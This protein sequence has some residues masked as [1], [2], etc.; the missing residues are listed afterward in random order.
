MQWSFVSVKFICNSWNLGSVRDHPYPFLPCGP[1]AEGVL[2]PASVRPSVHMTKLVHAIT[3]RNI[4]QIFLKLGL[5]IFLV[6]ISDKIKDGYRSSLSHP[7]IPG[8]TLCFCTGSYAGAGTAGRR[9]LYKRY[10]LNNFLY[11][12]HFWHKCWLWSKD[13]L[14]R[15]WSIFIVTLTLNFQGQIWNLL[16]LSQKWSDCHETKSKHINW[17]LGLKFYH[18]VWPWPWPWPW[19]FTVKHGICYISAKNGPIATQQKANLSIELKASNVTIR[20]DLGHDFSR[21]IM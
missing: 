19:I 21:S 4:F 7:G 2:L 20:Y 12:F 8:V 6:Y 11:F 10:L 5:D 15:F 14:I 9:L 3:L 1:M 16:Y 13:Y 17:T 18:R